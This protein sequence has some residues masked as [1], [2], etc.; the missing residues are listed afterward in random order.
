MTTLVTGAGGFVGAAFCARMERQGLS[1][2]A[3]HRTIVPGSDGGNAIAVGELDGQT[4]WSKALQGVAQVVHLAARVHVMQ[5]DSA[6]PLREFRRVNVD[7]TLNL[8]KQAAKHGVNRLVFVSSVKVNGESTSRGRPFTAD[9]VPAPSDP[10]GVSKHEAEKALRRIAADTGLE[11]VIIRPPLIYGPGVK[12]NFRAMMHWLARGV[13]L[14]L[15]AVNDNRRSLVALD[16]LV[17]LLVTCLSHPAAANQTFMVSDGDDL[18]TAELLR[19][20][21]QAQGTP[22]RLFYMP[23]TGLRLAAAAVG[24]SA[25]YQRLCGSLQVDIRKTRELLGWTPP[26]AL[27]EGLRRAAL[28]GKCPP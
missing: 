5:D 17:D 8:A 10:Y 18:S 27:D 28:T 2:C 22:A 25:V 26:V 3:A 12:A 19:R 11:V 16:N 15:S 23:V 7:G 24:K 13:P 14:P 6:D 21:G 9:D 20:M 4:D 1:W